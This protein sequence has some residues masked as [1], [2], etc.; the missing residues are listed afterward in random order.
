MAAGVII[1]GVVTIVAAT[2]AI[3]AHPAHGR[4]AI[5]TL[6][7]PAAGTTVFET[8]LR[9]DI[10]R[11]RWVF[12]GETSQQAGLW[13]INA[14]SRFTS[15]AFVLFDDRLSFRD[16]YSLNAS[17]HRPLGDRL[18]LR[19]GSRTDW[20]SLSRVLMQQAWAGIRSQVTPTLSVEPRL[21]VAV[22]RRPGAASTEAVPLRTDAGPAAGWI[23]SWRSNADAYTVSIMSSVDA[24]RIEPR[25]DYAF[26]VRGQAAGSSEAADWTMNTTASGFRRDTYEAASFL[27]RDTQSAL[28]AE[29]IEQTMSDTLAWDGSIDTPIYRDIRFA[30]SGGLAFNRRRVR[31]GRQPAETVFYETDFSRRVADLDVAVLSDRPGFRWR[32][33][34]RTGAESEVHTLA[35]RSALP[36]V[37]A[38]QRATLLQQ[39]DSER[40]YYSLD[41]ST[42]FGLSART[43]MTASSDV[44]LS[45]HD[46]P[47]VNPDD[48]DERSITGDFAIRT[49]ISQAVDIET[50]IFANR[51]ETVYIKAERSAENSTQS[52]LRW[53]SAVVWQP[54]D[55]TR[56]RVGPEVRA[57]Y[58]VDDFKLQGRPVR[59]QAAR[60]L[61]YDLQ[62]EHRS[63]N[64]VT[65]RVEGSRSDLR[66][67]QF[68]EDSFAEIPFDTL[69]T[70][71]GQ[72]RVRV[73]RRY[74]TEI[75]IRFFVRTDYSVRTRVSHRRRDE[76]GNILVDEEGDPLSFTTMRPGLEIVRQVGPVAAVSVR[77]NNRSALLFDGWLNVQK[78]HQRLY[79]MLPEADAEEIRRAA[80]RGSTRITPNA[81]LSVVWNL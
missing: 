13:S 64:N 61:R 55:R 51:Y 34:F 53:Q 59:D 47:E 56:L 43:V 81:S 42:R 5:E 78:Q 21:G 57:T 29:T 20:Y 3:A 79:G 33:G 80:E 15:D 1:R 74:T 16:E 58:T 54:S 25:R 45:R 77:L 11:Y 6:L 2:G 67:G 46:T 49:R 8:Q 40:G 35:N 31:A 44:R 10:N 69:R 27:N 50:R 17:A 71:S 4:Q 38:T 75:G 73:G 70:T 32:F 37:Q 66:L 36:P 39:A 28:F 63:T 62:F 18:M 12:S 65:L 41:A 26:F 19:F 30:G 24:R 52:S 22:D 48:R 72:V 9:R 76:S 68:L 7:T 23:A 60:E 14:G